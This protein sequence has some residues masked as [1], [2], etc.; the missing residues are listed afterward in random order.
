MLS[1]KK[2]DNKLKQYKANYRIVPTV[3]LNE[4]QEEI[5]DLNQRGKINPEIYNSTDST[6]KNEKFEQAFSS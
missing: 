4:L 6:A 5:E 3:H 2:L 1:L